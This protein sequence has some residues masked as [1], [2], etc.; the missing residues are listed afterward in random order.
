MFHNRRNGLYRLIR[1]VKTVGWLPVFVW[2]R[3]TLPTRL[4]RAAPGTVCV[5][6][7]DWAAAAVDWSRWCVVYASSSC[8]SRPQYH[9]ASDDRRLVALLAAAATDDR[10]PVRVLHGANS[11]QTSSSA[12]CVETI[13]TNHLSIAGCDCVTLQRRPLPNTSQVSTLVTDGRTDKQTNNVM[14]KV[15]LPLCDMG[16]WLCC[17]NIK[18]PIEQHFSVHN[19]D[20]VTATCLSVCR[21]YVTCWFCQ[22]I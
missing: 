22:N 1:P 16:Q 3:G 14:V 8:W 4:S 15:S 11:N 6:S 21:L 13:N 17:I 10:R 18:K 20:C 9:P 2:D 7:A 19:A 5:E 12:R